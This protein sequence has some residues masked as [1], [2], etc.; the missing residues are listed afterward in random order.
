MHIYGQSAANQL[1]I[2]I[3]TVTHIM[4]NGEKYACLSTQVYSRHYTSR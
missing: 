1:E 3:H 4:V 2:F